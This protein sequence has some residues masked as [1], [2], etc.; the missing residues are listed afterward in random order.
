M[1]KS[2]KMNP[3]FQDPKNFIIAQDDDNQKEKVEKENR[4]SD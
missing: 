1:V 3:L 2:E 4:V